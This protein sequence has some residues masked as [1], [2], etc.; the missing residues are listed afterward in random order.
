MTDTCAGRDMSNI[1]GSD[2]CGC[3]FVAV[4]EGTYNAGSR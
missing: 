2:V 1:E 4:R 3:D